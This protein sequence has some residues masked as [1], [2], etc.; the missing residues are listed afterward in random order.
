MRDSPPLC[1]AM[2]NTRICSVNA[3]LAPSRWQCS[4]AALSRVY[5]AADDVNH[6]SSSRF[7]A[8]P[9]PAFFPDARARRAG[10]LAANDAIQSALD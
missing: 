1:A 3:N 7:P 9:S 10:C 4:Y 8:S 6:A 5:S 2:N